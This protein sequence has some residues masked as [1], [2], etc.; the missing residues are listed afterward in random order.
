MSVFCDKKLVMWTVHER[1]CYLVCVRPQCSVSSL[2]TGLYKYSYLHTHDDNLQTKD[3]LLHASDSL[4][5]YLHT[6]DDNLQTKD[7]L[8][9]ASDSLAMYLYDTTEICFDAVRPALKPSPPRQLVPRYHDR[10]RRRRT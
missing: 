10:R 3:T 5:T 7:T 1:H 6:H 8:L 4:A 9:H 2:L